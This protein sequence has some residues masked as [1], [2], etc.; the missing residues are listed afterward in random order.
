[1]NLDSRDDLLVDIDTEVIDVLVLQQQLKEKDL[2]IESLQNENILLHS[3]LNDLLQ[4]LQKG[5]SIKKSSVKQFHFVNEGICIQNMASKMRELLSVFSTP[6]VFQMFELDLSYNQLDDNCV[7]LLM[8][9]IVE[10]GY[11]YKCKSLNLSHNLITV[12]GLKMLSQLLV[13]DMFIVLNVC[14][15][16]SIIT[17]TPSI[18]FIGQSSYLIKI[19]IISC[20]S[21][22]LFSLLKIQTC[23]NCVNISKKM[24]IYSPMRRT[25]F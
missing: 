5:A 1:M 4:Q 18:T 8:D 16:K 2:K 14:N 10:N 12:A 17:H 7:E 9:F 6:D 13:S 22:S 15:N 19:I 11:I 24:P 25:P 21:Y 3:K 20:N 23:F